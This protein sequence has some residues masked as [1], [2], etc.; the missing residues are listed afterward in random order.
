[1]N[2][3]LNNI[4]LPMDEIQSFC[5]KWQVMEF[6]LFGS[7]LR[8]D[9]RPDSDVDVMVQFDPQA[10]PTLFDLVRM[11]DELKIVFQRDV[12][13]VTRKGIASGR[14]Y[15]RRDAILSSTQVIYETRSSVSA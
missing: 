1:M 12:D 13:L 4:E 9:F 11:E 2:M 8:D 5:D 10:H 15:L 14:N 6:A 7:V 3:K